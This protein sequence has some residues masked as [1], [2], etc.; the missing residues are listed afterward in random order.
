MSQTKPVATVPVSY[1][2]DRRMRGAGDGAGGA[3]NKCSKWKKPSAL[4]LRCAP[5]RAPRPLK[6]YSRRSF[7]SCYRPIMAS[8]TAHCRRSPTRSG[9]AEPHSA[10]PPHT[11]TCDPRTTRTPPG[12]QARYALDADRGYKHQSSHHHHATAAAALPPYHRERSS[13]A[14]SP[15]HTAATPS[16]PACSWRQLP[17]PTCQEAGVSARAQVLSVTSRR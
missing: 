10:P 11:M 1:N 13:P 5:R 3:K 15:A 12:S 8:A 7:A 16:C 17:L 6:T 14:L 9:G 4:A 2:G